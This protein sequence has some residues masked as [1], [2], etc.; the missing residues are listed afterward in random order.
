MSN[1]YPFLTKTRAKTIHL[2]DG[3]SIE[4]LDQAKRKQYFGIN[5][6]NY[7]F[8][9]GPPC[10]G[11]N[12]VSYYKNFQGAFSR[13]LAS[14]WMIFEDHGSLFASNQVLR[15]DE[16]QQEES[17][18]EK[19]N[20]A[21][22]LVSP[23]STHCWVGFSD[24]DKN[25]ISFGPNKYRS[26]VFNYID[27]NSVNT[28]RLKQIYLLVDAN[29]ANQKLDV[30]ADFYVRGLHSDTNL[31]ARFLL[32]AIALE[33]L[34][35]GDEN[36]ELKYKFSLR[37]SLLAKRYY[38]KKTP[39][40]ELYELASLIYKIR[41]DIAHNGFSKKLDNAAFWSLIDVTR[42]SI[43]LYLESP[44]IFSDST[45]DELVLG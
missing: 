1:Y 45:M 2:N 21:L 27:L 24:S 23:T 31:E 15:I 17:V 26:G 20:L 19:L 13:K 42:R 44:E 35:L 33:A 43:N 39:K 18:K 22:N 25:S 37:L 29:S 38:Y 7:D 5:K 34:I 12:N 28:K 6:I 3:V 8:S 32:M 4:A 14:T 30:V 36:Q 41:C 10:F 40:Q 9:D 16:G 11:I